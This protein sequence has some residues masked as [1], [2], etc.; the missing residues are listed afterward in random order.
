MSPLPFTV[1]VTGANKGIGKAI[2]DRLI[3]TLPVTSHTDQPS[4]IYVASRDTQ[5]GLSALHDLKKTIEM[6]GD[7]TSVQ[8]KLLP[9]DVTDPKSV[10]AAADI[11]KKEVGSVDVLVNN[12]GL[13]WKGDAFDET[14]V[15]Q[16]LGVNYFG[17]LE[18][19]QRFLPLLKSEAR[20][21]NVSSRLGKLALLSPDLRERFT[22][23]E[24]TLK[25]LNGLI[26]QFMSDVSDGTYADKGWPRQAYGVSK[27]GVNAMTR[28][29][30][31]ILPENIL[32]QACCP[33]WVRTDMGGSNARLSPDDGADTPVYLIT[34]QD[35]DVL[36]N[37]GAFWAEK[38][39]IA[40]GY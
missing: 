18:V 31:K 25:Q 11:V 39:R 33:G 26:H 3:R 29:F 8:L 12:A 7:K 10:A 4:V 24:L 15:R 21:I 23:P 19:T 1:I 36:Q 2:V 37:P 22:D 35:E 14:V 30:A 40:S 38:K 32:I 20:I 17:I 13:A 9:L 5:R 27:I 6:M 28:I 34:T 16:T